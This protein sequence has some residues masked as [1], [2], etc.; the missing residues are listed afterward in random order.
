MIIIDHTIIIIIIYFLLPGGPGRDL[1][2]HPGHEADEE[3]A[4]DDT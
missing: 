4:G 2:V 3:G 1:R